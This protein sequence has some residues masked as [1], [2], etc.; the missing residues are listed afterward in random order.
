MQIKETDS[1]LIRSV[2]SEAE[3]LLDRYI[4]ADSFYVAASLLNPW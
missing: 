2:K 1:A 3:N 4:I